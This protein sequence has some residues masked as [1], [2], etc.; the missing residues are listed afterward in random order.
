MKHMEPRA[1]IMNGMHC[2]EQ[3]SLQAVSKV[4]TT[5]GYRVDSRTQ[6]NYEPRISLNARK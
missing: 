4:K 1:L 6:L 3:A 5:R 2:A